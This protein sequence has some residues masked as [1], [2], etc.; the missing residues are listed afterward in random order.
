MKKKKKSNKK[1]KH[2]QNKRH[3]S[4]GENDE[5]KK[6]HKK[7]PRA[8]D[9]SSVSITEEQQAL[10][11]CR[12]ARQLWL[13]ATSIQDLETVELFYRQ[14]LNAKRDNTSGSSS[15]QQQFAAL[16]PTEYRQA[17]EK[18]SLLYLQSGR[19]YKAKP[20]LSY[21]K[22]TCR[23]AE[24]ILNYPKNDPKNDPSGGANANKTKNE[25]SKKTHKKSH[26][27]HPKPPCCVVDDFLSPQQLHYLQD[28]FRDPHGDY[29]T[30]HNYSVEPPSPYFSYVIPI[31]KQHSNNS[32]H[33]FLQSIIHQMLTT[34]QT[35]KSSRYHKF[36][37]KLS[38]AR[39]VELWAHNR[40]HASGHQLHFDSDNEGHGG[41]IRNP[42]MSTILYL[43]TT[44]VGGPSLMTNQ[45]LQ[46]TNLNNIQGWLAYGKPRRMVAF[47]G[48]V[49]HG[50]IPGKGVGSNR[51][52]TLML[53]FWKDIQVRP[54]DVP[55]AA[56][57]WPVSNK[58]KPLPLW[59]AKLNAVVKDVMHSSTTPI[60]QEPLPIGAIYEDLDGR[61]LDK[62]D[63]EM[64]EYEQVFQGF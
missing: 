40:P 64:P 62:T 22:F 39:F 38:Q 28:I 52:V 33:S 15:K 60:W 6:K 56:R 14:A 26:S 42:I 5:S 18:L 2:H 37:H 34:L 58:D 21:L 44:E 51:R 16:S 47:D 23:L 50:V 20:G 13:N 43:N 3:R 4:E 31:D 12:Q 24:R 11:W 7:Q 17:G 59:A 29:W 63:M 36:L 45:T 61:S 25:Q 8:G 32:K 49:L 53:A 27:S 19:A 35:K 9:A 48:T 30:D 55:G 10:A 57:P 54:S 41:V 46:S 1:K